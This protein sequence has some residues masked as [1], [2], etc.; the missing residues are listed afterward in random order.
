VDT[1]RIQP[2]ALAAPVD[3]KNCVCDGATLFVSTGATGPNVFQPATFVINSISPLPKKASLRYK[4]ITG[5]AP[6][7]TTFNDKFAVKISQA[8]TAVSAATDVNTIGAFGFTPVPNAP[9][10]KASDWFTLTL[11]L[12]K[13]GPIT[14]TVDAANVG[15]KNVPSI[16]CAEPIL[17]A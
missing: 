7:T 11:N 17:G 6:G 10:Q 1:P 9:G 14:F 8:G 12:V 15:D 3:L 4:I 13:S 2:A 16:I 5:E